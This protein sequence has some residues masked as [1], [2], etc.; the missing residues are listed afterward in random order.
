MGDF[1]PSGFLDGDLF[2]GAFELGEPIRD[3]QL[4]G[5]AGPTLPLQHPSIRDNEGLLPEVQYYSPIHY[6]VGIVNPPQGYPFLHDW[7]PVCTRSAVSTAGPLDIGPYP[8]DNDRLTVPLSE[9][10]ASFPSENFFIYPDVNS[11]RPRYVE[12]QQW[13]INIPCQNFWN[14]KPRPHDSASPTT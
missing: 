10:L 11:C 7:H 4:A 14:L 13:N 2:L 5:G 8:F 3:N 1:R 6:R 12:G 9:Q